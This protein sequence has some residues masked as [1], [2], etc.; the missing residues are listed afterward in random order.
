MFFNDFGAIDP[1]PEPD[2]GLKSMD[3][4]ILNTDFEKKRFS[5]KNDLQINITSSQRRP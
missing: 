5:N 2:S 4:W 1:N 3:P